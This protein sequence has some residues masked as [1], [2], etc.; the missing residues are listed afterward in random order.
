M[1]SSKG[2]TIAHT[3]Q[4]LVNSLSNTIEESK[5][6]ADLKELA[7]IEKKMINGE[8]G[9]GTYSY[10]GK[11]KTISY[12]PVGDRGWSIGITVEYDDILDGVKGN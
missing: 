10:N 8:D 3:N 5:S 7:E 6:D 12:S 4:D 2:V 11:K 1:I 9:I